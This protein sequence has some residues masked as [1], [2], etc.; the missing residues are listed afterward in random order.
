MIAFDGHVLGLA[1]LGA[2]LAQVLT[3]VLESCSHTN[4]FSTNGGS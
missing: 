1:A 4:V 3:D 2:S